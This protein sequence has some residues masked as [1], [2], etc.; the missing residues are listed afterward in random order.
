VGMNF[1]LVSI[2]GFFNTRHDAG[3]EGVSF[4]EQLVDAFG[5]GAFK[6]RQSLKVAGLSLDRTN[7]P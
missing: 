6:V 1:S 5:I 7:A 4:F 3:F 2:V